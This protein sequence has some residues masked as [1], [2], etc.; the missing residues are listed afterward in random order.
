MANNRI[1]IDRVIVETLYL[2]EKKSL[3]E[4][5]G[6]LGCNTATI[7]N[8]MKE[9]GIPR[10]TVAVSLK[11][12]KHTWGD[13]ISAALQGRVISQEMRDKISSTRLGLNLPAWNKGLRKAT[14]PQLITY[15]CV[16]PDHWA[17]QGGISAENALLRQSSEYKQWRDEVFHRDDFTCQ[18]CER[19]GGYLEA[20]HIISMAVLL[21]CEVTRVRVKPLPLGM[22][23]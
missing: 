23:R 16:G 4:V 2:A 3:S 1:A 7:R 13:K 8:R 12:R 5:G 22:G 6:I 9:W 20:H 11:N 21:K 18:F 15:G 17:W 10:R 14:H 19:K